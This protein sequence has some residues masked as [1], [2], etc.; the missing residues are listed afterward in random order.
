[1]PPREPLVMRVTREFQ[2]DL[3]ARE[4]Q[5][6]QDMAR[7]WLSVENRLR[8]D[9]QALAAQVARQRDAGERITLDQLYQMQR[10]QVLLVQL[11]SEIARYAGMA[12]RTIDA[13]QRVLATAG[14]QDGFAAVQASMFDAWGTLE[15]DLNRINYGA[16]ERIVALARGGQPLA[17]LLERA[18]PITAQAISD[19]LIQGTALGWNPRKTADS[20][21]ADGMAQGLDHILLVARDQQI[22]VYREAGRDAYQQA[23]VLR[24]RR[25]AALQ[26]R[27]CA[28]C[29]ALDGMEYDTSELME[30]H[31]QDRC[32]MVPLVPGM[33]RIDWPTGP[34]WFDQQ[35]EPVQR[36]ILGPGALAAYQRGAFLFSALATRT[37]SPTWGP[38][39]KVTPLREL[40]NAA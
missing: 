13:E 12:E 3:L 7:G 18:Y 22:R 31:P 19:R 27:T 17:R 1:M 5:Q 30:L 29:L 36:R 20:I 26:D 10:Y 14:L 21:I 32:T 34:E 23:G 28:A 33:E 4:A 8:A 25:M 2:R 6:V 39:V 24:Y 37:Y 16:V 35:P 9:I 40:T 15:L 38:G 11:Q